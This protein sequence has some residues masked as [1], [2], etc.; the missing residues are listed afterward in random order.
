M[1]DQAEHPRRKFRDEPCHACGAPKAV[2][3]GAWLR[4]QRLKAGLTL[5]EMARRL[6]FSAVYISDV[7]RNLRHCSPKIREAYEQL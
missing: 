2:I 5:R 3:D 1:K 6:D 4:A 7:E